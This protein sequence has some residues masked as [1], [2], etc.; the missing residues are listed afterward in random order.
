MRWF[1]GQVWPLILRTLPDARLTIAGDGPWAEMDEVAVQPAVS[2]LG[3]VDDIRPY[4]ACCAVSIAPILAGAGTRI[5]ILD[6]LA[7]GIPIVSTTLGCEG[8]AARPGADLLLADTPPISPP[9][10]WASWVTRRW[11]KPCAATAAVWPKLSTTG[12]LLSLAS[13]LC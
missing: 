10:C 11:P 2:A 13:I 12:G 8:I 4:L 5:K 6:S 9:P 7:A 3:F 1:L